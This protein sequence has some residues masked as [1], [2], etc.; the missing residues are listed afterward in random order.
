[1]NSKTKSALVLLGTLALGIAL[2][3]M[4]WSA[5]HSRRMAEIQALR[6]QGA[7]TTR[8][9]TVVQAVDESQGNQVREVVARYESG[10]LEIYGEMATA[11]RQATD[12]LR[13]H[14]GEFLSDNQMQYLD[15]WLR[16]RRRPPRPNL[17]TDSVSTEVQN[18]EN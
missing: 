16:E 8:I 17:R 9:Q 4:L 7:L 14:L 10:L 11:R 2:G 13:Y 1:M 15:V 5:A 6:H 3:A 12:S 18:Q